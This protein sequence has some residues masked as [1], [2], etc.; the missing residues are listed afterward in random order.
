MT[1][2]RRWIKRLD[3]SILPTSMQR[4][5]G[6]S[7]DFGVDVYCKRDDLTGFAFGGNKTRKLD[8]LIAEAKSLGADTVVG[9]GAV[10]SNF[11]RLAA[12]AAMASGMDAHLVLGGPHK[13]KPTGNLLVDHIVGAKI[14]RVPSPVW[15]DWEKAAEALAAR[16]ERHGRRVYRM[17]IGGST[18]V[19]ALGYVDA[20]LEI[21]D[22]ARRL[23]SHF[24]TIVLTTSSGGTQAGLVVGKA[25]TGWEG[26][27]IGMAVAKDTAQ[28]TG[29]VLALARQTGERL[30]VRIPLKS[31]I[32]DDSYLG[33]GYAVH[34]KGCVNAVKYFATREG[35]M[36]DYVYTGKAAAGLLDYL[37]RGR[38]KRSRGVLFLHT[39]G[40]TELFA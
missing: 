7:E 27:I 21:L 5:A 35:I 24:D 1:K 4:C 37:E 32:V 13:G 29:E 26:R 8:Y 28:L 20:F 11:C 31:V 23:R 18:P 40:N 36:L 17:P 39:G 33:P 3:F 6:I 10:Q 16:L 12:A 30:G 34:T 25:L 19:G 22:D 2:V 9:V 14:H 38:F 15:A